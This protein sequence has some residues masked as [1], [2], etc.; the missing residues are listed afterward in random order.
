MTRLGNFCLG[1]Y[2]L[3]GL[4]ESRQI[5]QTE[6]QHILHLPVMQII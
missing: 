2:C 6:E 1:E 3:Y 5:I 4:L